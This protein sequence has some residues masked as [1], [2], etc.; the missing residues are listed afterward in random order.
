MTT[1]APSPWLTGLHQTCPACG[2]APLY[3]GLLRFRAGCGACG[4]DFSKADT[5]DGPMFFVI[6]LA[7]LVVA[8][9]ALAM[10][11]ALRPP[12]WVH[13]LVWV[14]VTFA[15]CAGMLRVA[16]ALLFALQWHTEAGESRH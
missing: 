16:K 13:V 10:Q 12:A 3:A 9:L 6:L 2:R 1:P 15:V 5:G 14:P 8:P 7:G 4:A 11:A